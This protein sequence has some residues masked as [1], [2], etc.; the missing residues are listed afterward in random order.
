MGSCVFSSSSTSSAA[1]PCR[2]WYSPITLAKQKTSNCGQIYQFWGAV[3]WKSSACSWT[4]PTVLVWWQVDAVPT[5]PT[6]DIFL[7]FLFILWT[8]VHCQDFVKYKL[9]NL[10]TFHQFFS[11]DWLHYSVTFCKHAASEMIRRP[12]AVFLALGVMYLLKSKFP[13][14]DNFDFLETTTS[15]QS[16]IKDYF[17]ICF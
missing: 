6:T 12:A 7:I 17:L 8:T 9:L 5:L 16:M 2:P 15:F 11:W 10:R 1:L 3:G 13:T 4:W 14:E